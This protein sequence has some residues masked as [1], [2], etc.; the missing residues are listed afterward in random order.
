VRLDNDLHDSEPQEREISLGTST[1]LGIFLALALVCAAFF[2]FGYSLGRHSS[3]AVASSIPDAKP[4]KTDSPF[5]GFKSQAAPSHSADDASADNSQAD[6][7][8][9]NPS[10]NEKTGERVVVRQDAAKPPVHDVAFP[11]PPSTAS[12]AVAPSTAPATGTQSIVQVSATS[13]EGDAESLIAALKQKG[14]AAAIRHESQ[15]Q[16]FHVQIGPFGT[17]K[18]AD[19]MR[20]R[21]D[22]DGYKAIVK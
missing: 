9:S 11:V 3:P 13:R 7:P 17:K 12:P 4:D 14:Y 19:A 22:T 18:E 8:S 20:Q 21:L 16:L 2:G 6:P 10:A 5:S 1:I 15:D